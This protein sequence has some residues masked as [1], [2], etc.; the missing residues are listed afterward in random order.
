[1]IEIN[2]YPSE[3]RY[4][5]HGLRR[6]RALSARSTRAGLAIL[7]CLAAITYV[8]IASALL[9]MRRDATLREVRGMHEKINSQAAKKRQIQKERMD[10]SRRLER[11]RRIGDLLELLER[12]TI[13]GVSFSELVARGD[14]VTL[15]GESADVSSLQALRSLLVSKMSGCSATIESVREVVSEDR[16]YYRQFNMTVTLFSTR[17]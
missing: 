2:L 11:A 17:G 4:R 13:P 1:M 7:L 9:R 3:I 16:R 10:V 5:Q 12:S 14:L 15:R 8:I 6:A